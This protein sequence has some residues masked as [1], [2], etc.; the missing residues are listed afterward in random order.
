M[1]HSTVREDALLEDIAGFNH[2]VLAFVD[3][4]GYPVNAAANFR[5]NVEKGTIELD[6]PSLPSDI[7]AGA[8]VNVTFSHV[9]PYP[10]V[11]YDQ[12]RYV[13]VWGSVTQSNGTLEVTPA[14]THGWDED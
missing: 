6:R 1:A 11:G 14:R 10:G 7:P 12:R 13:S 9:R 4:S 2:A 8:E 5:P 3:E